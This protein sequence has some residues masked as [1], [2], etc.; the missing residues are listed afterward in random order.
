MFTKI[1]R[2]FRSPR[3][4]EQCARTKSG[5]NLAEVEKEVRVVMA[6]MF[7]ILPAVIRDCVNYVQVLYIYPL[8]EET[9]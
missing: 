9:P 3:S 5:L 6:F 8:S 1:A 2:A 7:Y 4:S